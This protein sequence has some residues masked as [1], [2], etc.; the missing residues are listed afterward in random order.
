M[1][2]LFGLRTPNVELDDDP[3]SV[4]GTTG[5]PSCLCVCVRESCVVVGTL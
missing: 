3:T 5:V 2:V 1:E 4:V